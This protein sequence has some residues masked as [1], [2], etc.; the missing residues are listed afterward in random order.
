MENGQLRTP[1][2]SGDLCDQK[3]TFLFHREDT[4]KE[5]EEFELFGTSNSKSAKMMA[6]EEQRT[7]KESSMRLSEVNYFFM[8][9][10]TTI[11]II[12]LSFTQTAPFVR[13]RSNS[14]YPLQKVNKIGDNLLVIKIP[15]FSVN[16]M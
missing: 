1:T 12:K 9:E 7:E 11:F 8:F 16:G 14:H 13:H 6:A 15:E 2:G 10:E 3:D 5:E 4:D